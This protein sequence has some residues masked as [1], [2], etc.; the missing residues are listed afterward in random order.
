MKNKEKFIEVLI[1]LVS[2]GPADA[3]DEVI[4]CANSLLD[5]I[6]EEFNI[7]IGVRFDNDEGNF[8][9]VFDELEKIL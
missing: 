6:G 2:V 5:W 9:E 4:D 7:S 8:E 3:P 1:D